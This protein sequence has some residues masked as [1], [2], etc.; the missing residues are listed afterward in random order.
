MFDGNATAMRNALMFAGS[1]VAPAK[2]AG[3]LSGA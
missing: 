1:I 2:D 3:E